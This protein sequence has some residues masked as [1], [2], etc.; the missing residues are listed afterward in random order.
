MTTT[1]T[2]PI[3]TATDVAEVL[4]RSTRVAIPTDESDDSL[5]DVRKR[6]VGLAR[7]HHFGVVLYD[8]SNERWTDHPHPTGPVTADQLEGSDRIHLVEQLRQFEAAGVT[9]TAWLATVPAL[10]AM[11]DVL[12]ELDID[13]ILLPEHLDQPKMMDRI[14]I[15]SSPPEMIGRVAELNLQQPPVVLAVDSD[16]RVRIAT[17]EEATR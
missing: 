10:T 11:L 4:D 5:D 3:P 6:A 14:Q 12:Q 16:G 9:A 8:R 7:Q 13:A 1:S 17:P 15:G 2:D